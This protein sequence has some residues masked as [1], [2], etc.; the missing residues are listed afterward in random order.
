MLLDLLSGELDATRY[1]EQC[2]KLL[3]NKSFRVCVLEKMI[4][5][6]IKTLQTLA[7]DERAQQLLGLSAAQRVALDAAPGGAP[8]AACAALKRRAVELQAR[9]AGGGRGVEEELY[10][11]LATRA[12]A[13]GSPV[14]MDLAIVG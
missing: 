9:A 10:C 2:F 12:A 5:A 1:E 7:H 13:A 3:G 6:A 4:A 11:S 8:V 14:T